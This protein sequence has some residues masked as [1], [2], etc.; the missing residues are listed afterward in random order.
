MDELTPDAVPHPYAASKLAAE[1]A[2][3]AQARSGKVGAVILR[4]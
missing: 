1:L 4:L 3:E 2:V